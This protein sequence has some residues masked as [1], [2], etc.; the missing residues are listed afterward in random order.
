MIKLTQKDNMLF[1]DILELRPWEHNPK[2]TS[3]RAFDELVDQLE[4]LGQ[5]SPLLVMPDGTVLGGERRLK[6]MKEELGWTEVWV[7]IVDIQDEGGSW[8]ALLNWQEQEK[9]FPSREA[10]MLEYAL[11]HNHRAGSYKK[12]DLSELV[13]QFEI[14]TA[15]FSVDFTPPKEIQIIGASTTDADINTEGIGSTAE[16]VEPGESKLGARH[17]LIAY[18]DDWERITQA[19]EQLKEAGFD[20]ILKEGK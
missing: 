8:K 11:S 6:A 15:L 19:N 3:P 16:V 12:D 7:S 14:D 17:K 2:E 20:T 18:S 1:A 5:H 9:R 4:T 13:D 10:A